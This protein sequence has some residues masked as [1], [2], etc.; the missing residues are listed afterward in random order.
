MDDLHERL[1]ILK[2][3]LDD[4][5]IKQEVYDEV[6]DKNVKNNNNNVK[7]GAYT[8]ILIQS[9][10]TCFTLIN[11]I[12]VRSIELTYY[13]WPNFFRFRDI[14]QDGLVISPF[15]CNKIY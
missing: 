6:Y 14:C 4:G 5:L 13:R 10:L 12:Y 11:Y 8:I 2:K 15:Q 7:K 1:A 9:Q 3:C